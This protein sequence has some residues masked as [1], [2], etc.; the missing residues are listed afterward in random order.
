MHLDWL[1][2]SLLKVGKSIVGPRKSE[3][4]YKSK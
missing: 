4:F 1:F 2:A 3:A